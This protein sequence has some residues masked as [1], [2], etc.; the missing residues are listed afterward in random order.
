MKTYHPSYLEEDEITI[1]QL[2]AK[3]DIFYFHERLLIS[4]FHPQTC[5]ITDAPP[6]VFTNNRFPHNNRY[7]SISIELTPIHIIFAL[8]VLICAFFIGRKSENYRRD[9]ERKK[10]KKEKLARKHFLIDEEHFLAERARYYFKTNYPNLRFQDD[11]DKEKPNEMTNDYNK[12]EQSPKNNLENSQNKNDLNFFHEKEKSESENVIEKFLDFENNDKNKKENELNISLFFNKNLNEIF[13]DKVTKYNKNSERNNQNFIVPYSQK[14]NESL[15]NL[16]SFM[17]SQFM[18]NWPLLDSKYNLTV[19]FTITIENGNI[20]SINYKNFKNELSTDE[21]NA[22]MAV[23]IQKY[24]VKFPQLQK[25]FQKTIEND[26]S[27]W[28]NSENNLNNF[29]EE[30][31]F[32]ENKNSLILRKRKSLEPLKEKTNDRFFEPSKSKEEHNSLIS[33]HHYE[34]ERSFL[35][36]A[37][38]EKNENHSN[39]QKN[40]Y[41]DNLKQR[42][43]FQFELF[44][45]GRFNKVFNSL[46][47]VGK[48]GFGEVYKVVHKIENT[49]YAIKKVYLPLKVNEDIRNH[50]YFREVMSMTKFNHKNVIR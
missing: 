21:F 19:D 24:S 27:Y 34:R 26:H 7:P 36:L 48:G 31:K 14:K 9:E 30:I 42:K 46:Q 20:T 13:L 3:G 43:H 17:E 22:L 15:T 32:E 40:I 44:E 8:C 35:P 49:V 16:K 5:A 1:F 50:K 38:K 11:D 25:Y 37:L 33:N 41:I 39:N 10:K 18:S 23:I 47:E 2:T 4:P 12:K 28:E 6:S 45:N 29:N